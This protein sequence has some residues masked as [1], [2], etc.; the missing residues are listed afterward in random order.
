[1]IFLSL[2]LVAI[3]IRRRHRQRAQRYEPHGFDGPTE[4]GTIQ[5]HLNE[6]EGYPE[7]RTLS[8]NSEKGRNHQWSRADSFADGSMLPPA[9]RN[10]LTSMMEEMQALRTQMQRLE[11]ERQPSGFGPT[12]EPPPQYTAQQ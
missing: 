3:L 11:M 4:L 5:E 8:L 6:P 1:M 7:P 10:G 12:N 9:V 2:C